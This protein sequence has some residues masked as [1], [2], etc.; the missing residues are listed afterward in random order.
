MPRSASS[1]APAAGWSGSAELADLLR[2]RREGLT[3]EQAGLPPGERRRTRGLRREE[4]ALLASI[5]PTYYTYL[6][7][8][9]EVRPSRQVLDS[10][11]G[12]LQLS[13]AERVHLHELVHGTPPPAPERPPDDLDASPGL[14]ALVARLDPFPTYVK[15]HR[16][17]VIAANCAARALFGDWS[18]PPGGPRNMLVWMFLDPAAREV[19]PDWRQEAVAMVDRFRMAAARR[20]TDPE[21][22]ALVE[23]LRAE[24]QEFA[25]AWGR[26]GVSSQGGGHKRLWHPTIGEVTFE[27][28]V[29]RTT[30]D[31]D[32]TLVT[33]SPAVG[34][35]PPLDELAAACP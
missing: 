16:W 18:A 15:D 33:F 9:R 23:R 22:V 8:A 27:H 32:Q 1:A 35:H 5:S 26:H 25:D 24:A 10:L 20:P 31:H 11:A 19:Y 34:E 3:P 21:T 2:R 30:D 29:L 4:V 6:E 28:V 13:E 7:Q 17:E 12:A 14:S